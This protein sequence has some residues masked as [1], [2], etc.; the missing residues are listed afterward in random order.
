MARLFQR[1]I[2]AS[3]ATKTKVSVWLTTA[4]NFCRSRSKTR[5]WSS[6]VLNHRLSR[7]AWRRSFEIS[8]QAIVL[9]A[10]I[11]ITATI[12]E[13]VFGSLGT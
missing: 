5:R 6:S 10:T 1:M 4:A 8:P 13:I 7:S 11:S 2:R 3:S 12:H 9:D